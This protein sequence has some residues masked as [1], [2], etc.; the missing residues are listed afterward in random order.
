MTKREFWL[1]TMFAI[2]LL[3]LLGCGVALVI[4]AGRQVRPVIQESP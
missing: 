1:E 3:I 2:I 4:T